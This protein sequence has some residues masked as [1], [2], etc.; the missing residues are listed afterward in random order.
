M[1]AAPT[2][3]KPHEAHSLSGSA[4]ISRATESGTDPDNALDT[5]DD[6]DMDHL[7][8]YQRKARLITLEMDKMGMG[9][10]QWYIWSLCG[11][12]YFL[13]LLWAQAFGLIASPLQRELGFS[14]AQLAN[15]FTAFS[16]GLTAG[17]F[18]WGV[19]VDIIGNASGSM[20]SSWLMIARSEM[21]I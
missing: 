7:T 4:T 8:P 14:D 6:S 3:D 13:D 2:E 1:S 5:I 15:V 9:R 18:V 10:Y 11:L 12:G 16:S 20:F 21:G 19:L 17:A